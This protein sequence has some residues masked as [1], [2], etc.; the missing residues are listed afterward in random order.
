MNT[1][2]LTY[3]PE[4]VRTTEVLIASVAQSGV[5]FGILPHEKGQEPEMVVLSPRQAQN[6]NV[7]IGD[8]VEV[9]YV[10]NFPDHVERIK[11][12]AVAV[13]R[14]TDGTEKPPHGPKPT[15]AR[16]TIEQQVLDIVMEGEVW[17]RAELY[18][19]LFNESFQTLTASEVERARYEAIGH[20]LARLHDTGHIA[21][22][23]VYGPAKKNA[24]TLY[25][26]KSTQVL[27]RA[28]MGLNAAAE[29]DE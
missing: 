7:R 26:A 27:G 29:E 11:W 16:K 22:A 13:Y 21:C 15:E 5:A 20:S 2:R 8:T 6:L 23:K 18:V 28:L 25:Y 3:N 12:R 14:K 1:G 9:S 17:N 10:E 19:E 4:D 24:T